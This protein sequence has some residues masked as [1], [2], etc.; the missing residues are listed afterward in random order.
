MIRCCPVILSA[1]LK[2]LPEHVRSTHAHTRPLI[3][4]DIRSC[5]HTH[6]YTHTY[7]HIRTHVHASI[8]NNSNNIHTHTYKITTAYQETVASRSTHP[9]TP[10]RT[11]MF[12]HAHTHM[13]THPHTHTHTHT[14]AHTLTHTPSSPS[15]PH[16][17]QRL[18]SQRQAEAHTLN[19]L[20]E[21]ICCCPSA[22][23]TAT[24]QVN[25][26][27]QDL[28]FAQALML[29]VPSPR[30]ASL[31]PLYRVLFRAGV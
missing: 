27:G 19:P 9:S 29:A 6:M 2:C 20:H 18:E 13:H 7:T 12:T 1:T 15:P 21:L 30:A 26:M 23:E 11:H 17:H 25:C 14:H 31:A 16:P 10:P 28:R 24:N 8:Y 4:T 3:A 22:P 5:A